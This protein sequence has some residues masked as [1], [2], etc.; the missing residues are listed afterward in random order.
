MVSQVYKVLTKEKG[1]T[2]S[3][4]TEGPT[5]SESSNSVKEEI[6][7]RIPGVMLKNYE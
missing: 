6:E 1:D 4:E 7:V 3:G 5:L 2:K